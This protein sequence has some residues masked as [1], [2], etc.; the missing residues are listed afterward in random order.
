MRNKFPLIKPVSRFE[1]LKLT[2]LVLTVS[3]AIAEETKIFLFPVATSKGL[4]FKPLI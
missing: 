3:V 1:L 4:E 2:I